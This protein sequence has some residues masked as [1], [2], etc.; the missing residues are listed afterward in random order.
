[1]YIIGSETADDEV[2]KVAEEVKKFIQ[3]GGGI[4]EKHEEPGKKKLAYQIKKSRMG[5]YVVD[6]FS[7]PS[8]KINEVEHR[9]RTTPSIIRHLI[10]NLEEALIR[11]AKDKQNQA[12]MKIR[13]PVMAENQT[14]PLREKARAGSAKI[15]I[16]L[17][18]EIEKALDSKD[19]K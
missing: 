17:D 9:I 10:V 2:P 15:E 16:D 11:M 5:Y 4:I 1:M 14:K 8:D 7:A 3:D 6:T 12:K 13:T 18:A 19:L